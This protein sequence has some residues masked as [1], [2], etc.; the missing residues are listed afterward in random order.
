MQDSVA[1]GKLTDST[2]V[3]QGADCEQVGGKL[4]RHGTFA[5]RLERACTYEGRNGAQTRCG[6]C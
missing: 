4:V 5:A 1:T 6:A 3:A 2:R